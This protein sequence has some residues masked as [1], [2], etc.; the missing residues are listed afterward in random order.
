[1]RP[2]AYAVVVLALLLLDAAPAWADGFVQ[3]GTPWG[4]AVAPWPGEVDV[5]EARRPRM[6]EEGFVRRGEDWV[7]ALPPPGRQEPGL[8]VFRF[9]FRYQD[10]PQP[11][12]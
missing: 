1:M 4:A 10:H 7:R 2:C 8:D 12:R 3:R 5:D 9:R 6:E 11:N